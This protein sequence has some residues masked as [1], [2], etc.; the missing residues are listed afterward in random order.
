MRE[1]DREETRTLKGTG[2]KHHNSAELE[3]PGKL[4]ARILREERASVPGV[5]AYDSLLDCKDEYQVI[6]SL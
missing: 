6:N 2:T 1:H 3:G 4:Q 5:L